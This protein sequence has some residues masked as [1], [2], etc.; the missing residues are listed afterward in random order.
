MSQ[1]QTTDQPTA[2]RGR[3]TEHRQ[4]YHIYRKATSTLFLGKV[5]AEH[6]QPYHIL[7][8]S[9]GCFLGKMIVILER[10]P[11]TTTVNWL[12]KS[13]DLVYMFLNKSFLY[14]DDTYTQVIEAVYEDFELKKEIFEKMD[15]ICKPHT[16]LCTNTS[17][18]EIDLMSWTY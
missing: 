9:A 16:I 13:H 14:C 8:Q 10:S 17:T 18:F 3:V 7:K 15:R 5:I 12:V 4:P 1:S 2:P 11:R 6:R